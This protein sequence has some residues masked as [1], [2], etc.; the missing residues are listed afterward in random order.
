VRTDDQG[1]NHRLGVG[2]WLA[3]DRF[4]ISKATAGKSIRARWGRGTS[5]ID[6]YFYEKGDGKSQVNVQHNQIETAQAAEQMKAYW[7]KKLGELEAA[8]AG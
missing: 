2:K 7:G 1:R 3:D 8:L 6:V 5:R 4:L